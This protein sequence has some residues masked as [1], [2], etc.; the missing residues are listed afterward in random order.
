MDTAI[1]FPT[2][3]DAVSALTTR[4]FGADLR[5][6]GSPEP[7]HEYRSL[8]VGENIESGDEY[9]NSYAR[10]WG[11]C[12][13]SV[14]DVVTPNFAGQFRRPVAPAPER[15]TWGHE[16]AE[17]DPFFSDLEEENAALQ[18]ERD[19]WM[20]IAQQS[21]RDADF[22]RAM[23]EKTRRELASAEARIESL[24]GH[25]TSQH[26]E[27]WAKVSDALG[28]P[29]GGK[30]LCQQTVEA[31]RD[32]DM[33]KERC[34]QWACTMNRIEDAIRGTFTRQEVES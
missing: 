6:T 32:R 29:D 34:D 26:V 13:V 25:L 7:A 11:E 17:N 28:G 31:I 10:E 23:L 4:V 20:D 22:Y 12:V 2:L 30:S 19:M 16:V 15:W 21:Q 9:Y 14:G 5:I 18:R 24:N 3:K 27:S 8:G 33:W 1:T